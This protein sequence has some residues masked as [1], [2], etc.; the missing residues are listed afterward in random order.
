MIPIFKIKEKIKILIQKNWFWLVSN[1][2]IAVIITY[3]WQ[4][5]ELLFYGEIQHRIVDDIIVLILIWS[6]LIN[7][8]FAQ[9]FY[10]SKTE[11]NKYVVL[12]KE[13]YEYFQECYEE[14]YYALRT[15]ENNCKTAD[16]IIS[17]TIKNEN[18]E[19]TNTVKFGSVK[20]F[21]QYIKCFNDINIQYIEKK[22]GEKSDG[23]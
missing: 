15:V 6:I 17:D 8:I 13:K 5:L 7:V 11:L 10:I 1:V 14:L 16:L 9:K 18:G 2:V 22:L 19:E 4:G 23:N 3:G 20:S 21:A 12:D